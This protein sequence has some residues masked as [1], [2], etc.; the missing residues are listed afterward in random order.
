MKKLLLAAALCLLALCACQRTEK[1][2][3]SVAET[4]LNGYYT[5]DYA[6][7]AALCTPEFA[8]QLSRAADAQA[9][10]PAATAQKMKEALSGT[11]FTIVSV[12]LDEESASARVRYDLSVPGL[13]KP[14]PKILKLQIE[15][16]TALVDGIE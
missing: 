9:D 2:V 1:R 7:A 3:T 4:F 8:A 11:S 5:A 14:V 16:R 13:E 15:G 12:E 6:A 10:L